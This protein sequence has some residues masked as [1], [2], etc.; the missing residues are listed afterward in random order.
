MNLAL[1]HAAGL[2]DS[3]SALAALI[4]VT[5]QYLNQ[6]MKEEDDPKWRPIP[7]YLCPRIELAVKGKVTC[8]QLQPGIKWVR[9]KDPAWPHPE[10]RPLI[11]ISVREKVDA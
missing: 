1:K 9:I 6:L 3:A 4:E 7:D 11:D 5:P 8:E 10:G 2:C